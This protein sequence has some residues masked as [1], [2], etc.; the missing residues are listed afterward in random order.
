MKKLTQKG[1]WILSASFLL[2]F[3]FIFTVSAQD[4][5][6]TIDVAPNVLNI[7][8]QGSLVTVHTDIAYGAVS[9]ATVKLNGV[10]INFWKSDNQGNFVAKFLMSEIKDLPLD[11]DDYNT[12]TLEGVT[13]TGQ[14]FSGSQEI[15]VIDVQPKGK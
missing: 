9:G 1:N 3:L 4:L 10:E 11:I 15:L 12:L 6:I 8:S 5:Q 14:T 13:K 7:Q 2:V